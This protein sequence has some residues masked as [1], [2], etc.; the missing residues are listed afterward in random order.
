MRK[1]FF[2]SLLAALLLFACTPKPADKM[3]GT[4]TA[5]A[6]ANHASGAPSIPM[7]TGDIR[8]AAPQAGAAPKIQIGKAETFRLDNGLS[9]IL[10][11]NHKLPQVSYRIFVDYDPVLEKEAAGYVELMGEMLNKGTATRSKAQIDEAVDF[12]GASLSSDANGVNGSSLS[13][14]SDQLLTLLS[15]VLLHPTFPAE[16]FE[17]VKRRTQ[18]GLAQSKDD[19][20]AIR[21]RVS[22]LLNYGRN[23]PYGETMTEE[24]LQKVTLDQMKTHYQTYFKPNIAYLVIVGD[25]NRARAEQQAKQYFGA[26]AKGTVPEHTYAM[27]AAPAKAQVSFVNKPGAVQSSIGVT[28]PVDLKPGTDAAIR[29]RVANTILGAYFNS[30]VN[31][32]LREGHGWTYGAGSTLQ[33]DELVGLFRGGADVRNMVTD[34]SLTEFIKEMNRMRDEPVGDVELQVVK[35]VIT[36]SFSR[37]LEEPGTAAQFA[38]NTARY[39]LPADYYEKYLQVLQSVSAADVQAIAKKYITAD[40]ANIVVVG[41]QAEV[42]EKLK[43]FAASGQINYYDPYGNPVAAP[44]SS[45]IPAGMSAEKVI[46]DYVNAIG[47]KAKIGQLKDLYS[48]ATM[49]AGGQ[50][51]SIQTWQKGGNK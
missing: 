40:R 38:L 24:T 32:N 10:V 41:N 6:A 42:A 23:H 1:A 17:K 48:K 35:N 49:A 36:G 39:K 8:K 7:P 30:R 12:I 9:V 21:T 5:P 27:P 16:E 28:Y 18:S 13:K 37:S 15:D 43:P 4:T 22:A 26:W 33:P 45:A 11:E 29:A 20:E 47:G 2:P 19:P 46:E 31:A 3:S 44:S 34:S 50:T 25:I 51:L 14:H